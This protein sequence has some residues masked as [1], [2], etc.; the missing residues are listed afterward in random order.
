[1]TRVIVT[2]LCLALAACGTNRPNPLIVPSPFQIGQPFIGAER[3]E[4]LIGSITE[5]ASVIVEPIEGLSGALNTA[6]T[7]DVVA[8]AQ[9]SD[10]PLSAD[11]PSQSADRL[12]GRFEAWIDRGQNLNGTVVW[13]LVTA[14][15][16]LIDIFEATAPMQPFT[17]EGEGFFEMENPAW[18]RAVA[19]AT[20]I[21]LA[22][23]LDARPMTARRLQGLAEETVARGPPVLVPPIAGAPGDG[24]ITLTRAVRAL[25]EQ[26]GVFV[27]NP[28]APPEGFSETSA[29]T[30]RGAVAM[31]EAGPEGSQPI[32]ISWDLYSPSGGHLGNVA[33]QNQIEAGSLDGPW[34]EVAI[35]AAM[36]AV[37]GIL[38][39][40]ALIP[41]EGT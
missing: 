12:R 22:Q 13:R 29:Y 40:L 23:V 19:E 32:A 39:L 37:E 30:L 17:G 24:E 1:M 28:D 16:E 8:A 11:V 26:Q 20:V 27:I 5:T 41:S 34:G 15:G 38:T 18:R 25:L 36:G 7:Q 9:A 21:E 10:I 2:A 33:Q 4:E 14:D 3:N 35:Y 6:L 31:G